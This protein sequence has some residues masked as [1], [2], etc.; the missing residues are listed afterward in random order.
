MAVIARQAAAQE[1]DLAAS[2]NL[3]GRVTPTVNFDTY[4]TI[5]DVQSDGAAGRRRDG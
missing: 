1:F 2:L 4:R 5:R 3:N